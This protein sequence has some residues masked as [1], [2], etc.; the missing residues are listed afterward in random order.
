MTNKTLM[1]L[2]LAM[3]VGA[4]LGGALQLRYGILG[5]TGYQPVQFNQPDDAP[6]DHPD[7]ASQIT[8]W[9]EQ[10]EI[11]LEHPPILARTPVEFVTHVS[12]IETAGPSDE[13]LKAL[14]PLTTDEEGLEK[15]L[16]IMEESARAVLGRA[17]VAVPSEV[18]S[19]ENT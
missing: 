1:M 2:L 7:Q 16:E 19:S 3:A 4:A 15:G 14:P 10:F 5:D 17:A 6:H 12:I 8:V 18:G 9:T 11:F 13:V